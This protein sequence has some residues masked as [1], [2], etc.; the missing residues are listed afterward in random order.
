MAPHVQKIASRM[1]TKS[2]ESDQVSRKFCNFAMI[3]LQQR[4]CMSICPFAQAGLRVAGHAQLPRLLL[5]PPRPLR[6]LRGRRAVPRRGRHQQLRA[7][8]RQN[9]RPQGRRG[10]CR[11]GGQGDDMEGP[12]SKVFIKFNLNSAVLLR[13]I[14][15]ADPGADPAARDISHS[16]SAGPQEAPG[17]QGGGRRQERL[18]APRITNSSE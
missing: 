14:S 17:P 16:A 1:F 10:C 9:C 4:T 6:P 15:T 11:E 13:L 7:N 12:T 8:P 5:L 3:F 2:K 18:D